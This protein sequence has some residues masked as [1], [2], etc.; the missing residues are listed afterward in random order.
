LAQFNL[1]GESLKF[2]EDFQA[3]LNSRFNSLLKDC[4]RR[5]F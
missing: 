3:V 2:S 5:L 1:L 4:H